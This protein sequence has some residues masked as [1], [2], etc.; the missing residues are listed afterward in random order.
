MKWFCGPYKN[1]AAVVPQ[2]WTTGIWK[3]DAE[4]RLTSVSDSHS[5]TSGTIIF[6]T[7]WE[8]QCWNIRQM[9]RFVEKEGGKGRQRQNV[10]DILLPWRIN[11]YTLKNVRCRE[12]WS[13]NA[14]WYG[15]YYGGCGGNYDHV[16]DDD[17][18]KSA[19]II[20]KIMNIGW[21]TIYTSQIRRSK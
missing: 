16:Y 3:S 17:Q 21:H 9:E 8:R 11:W 7:L 14:S 18:D 1:R 19:V 20:I 15:S 13:L 6:Y 10:L 2:R 4:E 5:V 12:C